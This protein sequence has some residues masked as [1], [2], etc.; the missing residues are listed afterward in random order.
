MGVGQISLEVCSNATCPPRHT[1]IIPHSRESEG[2]NEW[3]SL[4]KYFNNSALE[5]VQER[6]GFLS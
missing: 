6:T 5:K 2:K 4:M 1:S 3:G